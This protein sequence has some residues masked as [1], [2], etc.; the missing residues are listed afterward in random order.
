MPLLLKNIKISLIFPSYRI[1]EDPVSLK[2]AKEHLGIIPPLSLAYVAAILEKAG[3]T[4]E[5]IDASALN[6]TKDQVVD[7]LNKFRPDFLGFTFTTI[8]F[9]YTLEWVNYLKEKINLPVIAGGIHLSVYPKETLTHKAIDYGVIG[10]AEETLPQLVDALVN[11]RELN[12]IKG[13]CYRENNKIVVT[14][15]RPPKADR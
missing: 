15:K 12:N 8:D 7:R 9:Q 4:V 5:L 1:A 6:L 13:I 3:C 11:K 14:E 2:E 10:E